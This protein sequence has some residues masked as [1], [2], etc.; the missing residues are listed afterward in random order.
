MVVLSC[1]NTEILDLVLCLYAAQRQILSRGVRS[2]T[3]GDSAGL[4]PRVLEELSREAGRAEVSIVTALG[5][6]EEAV[7]IEALLREAARP[8][9]PAALGPRRPELRGRLRAS[10]GYAKAAQRLDLLRGPSVFEQCVSPRSCLPWVNQY[11]STK[12]FMEGE[13]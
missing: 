6:S 2:F 1:F 13:P 10:E 4:P 11:E 12:L 7:D 3:V 8:P 9:H 5:W